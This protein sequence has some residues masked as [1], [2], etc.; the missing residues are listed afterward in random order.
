M[1]DVTTEGNGGGAGGETAGTPQSAIAERLTSLPADKRQRLNEVAI[2]EFDA[3]GYQGASTNTITERAG[4]SK[5]LLFHYFGSKRQLYIYL[6]NEAVEYFLA[7]FTTEDTPGDLFARLTWWGKRKVWMFTLNPL[8]SRFVN[9]ALRET[10]KGLEADM[11]VVLKRL[12]AWGMSIFQQ[13]LDFSGLRPDVDPQRAMELIMIVID[14]LGRKYTEQNQRAGSDPARLYE[15]R[16][17]FAREVDLHLD[18]LKRGLC[19]PPPS[20]S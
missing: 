5:G 16:E 2:E 15:M 18:L 20:D 7:R 12:T 8:Y 17:A 11:A 19:A 3:H 13:G 4:I 14:G 1:S 6:L 10:P 9:R